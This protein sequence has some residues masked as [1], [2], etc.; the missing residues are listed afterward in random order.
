MRSMVAIVLVAA[1]AEPVVEMQLMLPKK[2]VPLLA[3]VTC[4]Q[5]RIR[6]HHLLKEMQLH[7]MEQ[8]IPLLSLLI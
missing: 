3:M 8:P 6:F 4:I 5:R 2:P 7:I 1:C